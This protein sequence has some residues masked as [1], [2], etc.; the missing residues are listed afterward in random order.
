MSYQE[1]DIIHERADFWVLRVPSGYEL[2]HK[3][4]THSTRVGRYGTGFE[5]RAIAD[6]DKRQAYADQRKAG[7]CIA[8]TEM[9][10]LKGAAAWSPFV[11]KSVTKRRRNQ[12]G[13]TYTFTDGSVLRIYFNGDAS[14]QERG[15]GE[16]RWPRWH[17]CN[18]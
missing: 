7:R 1:K 17:S 15:N 12:Y 2:Y 9:E 18:R 6:C 11:L 8:V 13:A 16:Q 10:R 4:S 14:W 3:G 5:A